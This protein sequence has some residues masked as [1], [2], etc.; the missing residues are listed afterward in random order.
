MIYSRMLRKALF[1]RLLIGQDAVDGFQNPDGETPRILLKNGS[2][3]AN[4]DFIAISEEGTVPI[5][6]NRRSLLV[7]VVEEV[8]PEQWG[9]FG[10]QLLRVKIVPIDG[11]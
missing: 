4:G 9:P 8:N 1:E 7:R 5:A 6:T 3:A 2:S 11:Q 10:L